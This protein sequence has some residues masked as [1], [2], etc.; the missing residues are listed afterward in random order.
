MNSMFAMRGARPVRHRD[1][2]TRGDRRVRGVAVDLP[3]AARRQQRG[4]RAHPHEVIR[5]MVQR[6]HAP[7]DGVVGRGAVREQQVDRE[8]VLEHRDA[9]RRLDRLEQ[10]GLD[11][12]AG[13]VARVRDTPARVSA[14]APQRELSA[15]TQVERGPPLHQ[16]PYALRALAHERLDGPAMAQPRARDE[17]VADVELGSSSPPSTRRCRPR[18]VRARLARAPSCE[19]QHVADLGHLQR[20]AEPGDAAPHDSTSA[21]SSRRPFSPVNC[22][23]ARRRREQRLPQ[24]RLPP[25]VH[26]EHRDVDGVRERGY[27]ASFTAS[28]SVV[29]IGRPAAARRMRSTS[30]AVYS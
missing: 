20:E 16:L 25:H 24:R 7:A 14:F 28:F 2:V 27:A 18:E 15:G 17:R 1:P 23:P 30:A 6:E 26:S 4:A 22:R 13:P 9:R 12:S 8:V 3:A 11:R 5:T 21:S 29:A 19:E 10:S